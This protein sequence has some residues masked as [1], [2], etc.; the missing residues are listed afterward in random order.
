MEVVV[1][2]LCLDVNLSSNLFNN[3]ISKLLITIDINRNMRHYSTMKYIINHIFSVFKKLTHLI[4]SE[5]SYQNMIGL[6]FQYPPINFSSSTLLVLNVKVANFDICLYILDGRFNQLHT[7]IV[8][9][10]FIR[11]SEK[12]ENQVSLY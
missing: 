3:Q 4:F 11:L 12:V 5:S 10:E 8:E 6:S 1:G 9:S 2:N 7:L